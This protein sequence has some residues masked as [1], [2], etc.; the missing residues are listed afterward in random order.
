VGSGSE[1]MGL[2]VTGMVVCMGTGMGTVMVN[3]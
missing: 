3:V 2:G 1:V